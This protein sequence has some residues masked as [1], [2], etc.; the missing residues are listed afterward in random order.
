MVMLHIPILL[1]GALALSLVASAKTTA[2]TSTSI[3]KTSISSSAIATP[4]AIIN[5]TPDLGYDELYKLLTNFWDNFLYPA[6]VTQAKAINSTIFSEDINGRIDVTRT[7]TGREL[8]TEYL[9]GLFANLAANAGQLSLL[10][11][12]LSYEITK[13]TANKYISSASTVVT[14]N[15]S[16]LGLVVPIEIDTWTAWNSA[17]QM[18]QYDGIFKYWGWLQDYVVETA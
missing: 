17:G 12:P 5:N 13:F 7:F 15:I 2:T 9:F 8:N 14:F 18:T 3:K 10:G 16:S 6:D 4:T 11:V 1:L